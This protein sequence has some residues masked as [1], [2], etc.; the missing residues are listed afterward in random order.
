MGGGGQYRGGGGSIELVTRPC[1]QADI[2]MDSIFTNIQYR[3]LMSWLCRS[4]YGPLIS[5]LVIIILDTIYNY[6][7][8]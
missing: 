1:V 6:I 3:K 8:I 2:R 5:E 7:I 4:G